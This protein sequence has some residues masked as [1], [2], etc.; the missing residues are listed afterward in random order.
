MVLYSRTPTG[1]CKLEG[2]SSSFPVFISGTT[3]EVS[4]SMSAPAP[5]S[6]V[7]LPGRTQAVLLHRVIRPMAPLPYWSLIIET[8]AITAVACV[9]RAARKCL[10]LMGSSA[11]TTSVSRRFSCLRPKTLHR[12]PPGWVIPKGNHPRDR[13]SASQQATNAA[14]KTRKSM[15]SRRWQWR[16]RCWPHAWLP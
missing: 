14:L 7:R 4:S 2:V 15:A 12:S 8:M 13:S 10:T 9:V 16:P 11:T 3:V 6:K 5:P 1:V